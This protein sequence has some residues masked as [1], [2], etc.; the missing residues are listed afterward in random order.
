MADLL[1]SAD[2]VVCTPWYEPFGIVPLEAMACGVPVVGSAVG[3]LLD[4]V[5]DGQTG[6]LVPPRDPVAIARAVRSL[7]DSRSSVPPSAAPVENGCSLT[8]RGI[9]SPP[10]RQRPTARV[11]RAHVA[12]TELDHARPRLTATSP[13]TRDAPAL[14]RDSSAC[15]EANYL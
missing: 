13:H 1:R 3:G 5:V 11:R 14:R 6:I 15:V 9:E 2:V 4:S 8:T 10:R 12:E 7:L